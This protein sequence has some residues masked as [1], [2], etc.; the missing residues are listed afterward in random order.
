MKYISMYRRFS[1]KKLHTSNFIF[2]EADGFFR[3][4]LLYFL[5]LCVCVVRGI[6]WYSVRYNIQ[7]LQTM[8]KL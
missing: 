2:H 1:A 7:L 3:I 4:V 5:I 6:I 8:C